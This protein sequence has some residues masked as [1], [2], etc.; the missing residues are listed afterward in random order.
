MTN[1][2]PVPSIVSPIVDLLT[3]KL[4]GPWA[5]FFQQF[6]QKASTVIDISSLSPYTANQLGTII[7][8]G[9]GTVKLIRG[10]VSITLTGTQPI[11]PISIGDTVSWT[12]GTAKFLG[13]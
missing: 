4:T 10:S 11:I 7:I 9:G 2:R 12:S 5:L 1:T 3:G 13:A 6:V 8:T